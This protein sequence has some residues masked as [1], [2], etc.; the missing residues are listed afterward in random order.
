M[1]LEWGRQPTRGMEIMNERGDW[2]I[3]VSVANRFS[4][5]VANANQVLTSFTTAAHYPPFHCQTFCFIFFDFALPCAAELGFF[6][7]LSP[8]L[9]LSLRHSSSISLFK[10]RILQQGDFS[11]P[12]SLIFLYISSFFFYLWRFCVNMHILVRVNSPNPTSHWEQFSV[13]YWMKYDVWRCG[14]NCWSEISDV[15]FIQ[16]I[17]SIFNP[18]FC[19]FFLSVISTMNSVSV[20]CV[21]DTDCKTKKKMNQKIQ[22]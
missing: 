20:L 1:E 16:F 9:S 17:A 12:S 14:G 7:Y 22:K 19:P 15:S 13:R 2:E 8:S 21:S 11:Y 18:T 6:V 5:V 4:T 10:M 3:A